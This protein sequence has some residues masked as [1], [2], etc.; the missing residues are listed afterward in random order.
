[1][2]SPNRSP[3][4]KSKLNA[5]QASFL[6]EFKKT[7]IKLNTLSSIGN[8]GIEDQIKK[9]IAQVNDVLKECELKIHVSNYFGSEK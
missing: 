5:P 2:L 7:K 8:L 4:T 9:E 6:K 3:D 1:M